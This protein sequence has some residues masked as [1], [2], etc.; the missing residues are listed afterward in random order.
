MNQESR[1]KPG[2]KGSGGSS[3]TGL[4]NNTPLT[5]DTS[6]TSLDTSEAPR[7]RSSE[8]DLQISH[9]VCRQLDCSRRMLSPQGAGMG[10]G[11]GGVG[12]GGGVGGVRGVGRD[13]NEAFALF[14]AGMTL[15]KGPHS[16]AHN[17]FDPAAL[18]GLLAEDAGTGELQEGGDQVAQGR[19]GGQGGQGTGE[20]GGQGGHK[21]SGQGAGT[22]QGQGNGGKF[23]EAVIAM[24]I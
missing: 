21:E 12:V 13:E 2:P 20:E 17:T 4:S 1:L 15:P 7:K 11:E 6:L 10:V 5:S 18:R 24:E 23:W 14:M 8:E 3:G 19:Q 22:G 16:Q 9:K